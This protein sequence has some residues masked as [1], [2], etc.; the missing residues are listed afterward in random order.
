MADPISVD[1]L[2]PPGP[3]QPPG[4]ARPTGPPQ[5]A[6]GDFAALVR[7]EL[8]KVS[9]MQSEAD[10]QVQQLLAGQTQNLS[11]VFTAARKAQVAFSLLMEIRNK[12]VDAYEE[13]KNMRV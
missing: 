4:V 1:K 11:E 13:L 3:I 2:R 7:A 6:A 5:T 10:R 12:L 9:Q 8:E